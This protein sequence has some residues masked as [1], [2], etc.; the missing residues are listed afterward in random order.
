MSDHTTLT[1]DQP[2][3]PRSSRLVFFVLWLLLMCSL[4]FPAAPVLGLHGGLVCVLGVLM[5][6]NPPSAR[7]PKWIFLVGGIFV[8]LS[9]TAFLPKTWFTINE[10]R[11]GLESAGLDTGSKVTA[12]PSQSWWQWVQLCGIVLAGLYILGQRVSDRSHLLF[13]WMFSLA[14]AIM[15]VLAIAAQTL[16]WNWPW[17]EDPSFGFFPNRNHTATALAMGSV[18]ALGCLFHSIR[19]KH[20]ALASLAALNCCIC[21]GATLAF[22]S[23]RA[24]LLLTVVGSVVWLAGLGKRYFSKKLVMAGGGMLVLAVALFFWLGG[25][26]KSRLAKAVETVQVS[27][28]QDL[29]DSSQARHANETTADFRLLIFKD[30][31]TMI[32]TEPIT[33][34][35]LGMFGY[36]FPQY[37]KA[38]A[39]GALCVHPESD[40]LML[41]GEQ[42]LVAALLLAG[43]VLGLLIWA[44][45]SAWRRHAWSL[46]WNGIVVAALVP[47]HGLFDVPGHRWGIVLGAVYMLALTLREGHLS[48]PLGA[49]GKMIW[50]GLGVVLLGMGGVFLWAGNDAAANDLTR[51]DHFHHEAKALYALDV[52]ERDITPP[53]DPEGLKLERGIA[54]LGE[55]IRITPLDPDLHYLRG[56]L[57]LNFTDEKFVSMRD[58]EFE[59]QRRLAPLWV[60]IPMRQAEVY[61][62]IDSKKTIALWEDGFRRAEVMTRLGPGTDWERYHVIERAIY[63]S[64]KADDTL[65]AAAFDLAKTDAREFVVWAHNGTLERLNESV[66]ETL[67]KL[68]FTPEQRE[69]VL[70]L[71]KDKGGAEGV[72]KYRAENP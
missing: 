66:P 64:Y 27:M 40:W 71:W 35:G 17:D 4:L 2:E 58:R 43:G 68:K 70:K 26:V 39:S 18:T 7:L 25:E 53:P 51:P 31:W 36:V 61:A 46:R 59:F 29:T 32:K 10:W 37:R 72:A 1:I 42:G 15:S 11:Q 14:V 12:H 5:L 52:A 55:A 3:S 45:R 9:A 67:A 13:A 20:H 8:L 48:R 41:A 49:A 28:D 65:K 24:G 22:C 50:R 44:F 23:S 60:Q 34:V 62:P 21:L 63:Q 33:G 19:A 16:G 57:A 47:F 6:L 54:L 30:A 56:Y 38:S 69:A